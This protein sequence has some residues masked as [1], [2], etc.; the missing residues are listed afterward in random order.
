[1]IKMT[2]KLV[3]MIILVCAIT[4]SATSAFACGEHTVF[5]YKVTKVDNGE[6]WGTGVYDD[7]SVY[8]TQEFIK[9]GEMINVNDVVVAYFE[10]ENVVDGLVMVEKV[11]VVG[12]DVSND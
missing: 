6:Y 3:A 2:M 5:I 7:S 10:P 8:F 1:M 9:Q 12:I 4:L 11:E